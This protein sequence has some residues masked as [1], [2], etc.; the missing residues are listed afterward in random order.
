MPKIIDHNDYRQKLLE[1]SLD[2][3]TSK[4]YSNINM[5]EVAAEIGVS[6]GTLYHYF[7]AKENILVEMLAWIGNKNI[8]EYYKRYGFIKNI[9]ERFDVLTNFLKESEELYEKTMLLAIDFYRNSDIKQWKETYFVFADSY[10]D[11]WSDRLNISREFARF[12]YIYFLGLSFHSLAFDESSEYQAQIDFLT[13]LFRPLIVDAPEDMEKAA[14]K[15][16]KITR[17][18]LL[19]KPVS[20]KSAPVKKSKRPGSRK[21]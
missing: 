16:K 14:K 5:K 13:T 3:L 9:R 11:A 17:E 19:K 21:M 15:I 6:T 8:D 10:T 2:L 7:P 12:L 20:S 18:H 4:G 1:K